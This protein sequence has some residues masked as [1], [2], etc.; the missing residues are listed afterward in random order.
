MT[1]TTSIS[2]NFKRHE[3]VILGSEYAGEMKKGVSKY[4]YLN[5]R[6]IDTYML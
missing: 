4:V 5:I 1:S 6:H 2:V 3:M